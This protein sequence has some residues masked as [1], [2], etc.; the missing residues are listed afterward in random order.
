MFESLA[1]K[2]GEK[3]VDRERTKKLLQPHR[4]LRVHN[5]TPR[6]QLVCTVSVIRC[7]SISSIGA[8]GVSDVVFGIRVRCV[9]GVAI[10]AERREINRAFRGWFYGQ[11]QTGFVALDVVWTC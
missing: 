1:P 4:S 2:V 11:Q 5:S 7:V 10:I 3:L 9:H 8:I 6:M